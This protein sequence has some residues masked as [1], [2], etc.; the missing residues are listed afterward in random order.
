MY[1]NGKI[2]MGLADGQRVELAL[3]MCNRHGLIAGASGTGKTITMKVMAESFSDAGV[4]VF[5]CDVK[6]DVAGICAPGVSNEGMEKRIDKFGVRDTFTYKAYPTTFWDIYQE[7]GHA[8]RATVSD[9]GPELLSRILGLTPAQ[10]GILHI[11]FRIADNR[12]LLLIDLKDLRAMLTYVNEHRSEYM[13]TYGNITSQSVAAILRALLPLEQQGGDL[14]FGEPALDIRDWIRTDADGHGM[15]NVL[16]CVK[17]VQNPTLYA[18]FLLWMLSEL[19]ENLP[20]AGDLDKPKLVFF[21]D[22]AHMLFRDAPAVLL[23]KIEQ[24]VK[25]IRSRGV[26]V[27]FVTQSP[28][29][30]P[31]AVLAQLSNRVQHALRA[32]TPAELK[33]VRVAAQAFRANPAFQAEDAIMELGVGEALTSFLD[34]GGVPA[35]V[36][37]TKI[38]CPQSLMTAPEPMARAKVLMRD[39][40]EKY[41]DYVDNLSA[42]EVLTEEAEKAETAKQEE[43]DRKAREKAEAEAE[44]KRLKEEE[45]DK[46]RQQKLEDEARKRQQKLDD[47]ARRRQQKLEDEERRKAERQQ[48]KAEAEAKRKAERRAAKIETQLISAGG[49]ILKRGLLGVLKKR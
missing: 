24:T 44:K 1:E 11:V 16:D 36:Q 35:M 42:Y 26:G 4:P 38:I 13:M 29:D 45:A 5:L 18:G 27:F 14:F 10:E 46:K 48:E 41:D 17:L 19:F 12:G 2:Y 20:E 8:V 28:S 23:Q 33:A 43:A 7:G 49:Q 40:M 39:G 25:L 6:G 21:F 22:E 15:I 9:M 31:N 30:I 3:N 34:E 47:E 32:Y 37:R